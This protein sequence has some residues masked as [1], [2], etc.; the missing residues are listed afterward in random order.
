MNKL[1]SKIEYRKRYG[2]NNATISLN[3]FYVNE[4]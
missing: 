1:S 3:I 2:K 4:K